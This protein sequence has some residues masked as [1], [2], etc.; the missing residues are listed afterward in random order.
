MTIITTYEHDARALHTARA[1][2]HMHAH[3]VTI[4]QHTHTRTHTHDTHTRTRTH[5]RAHT[6]THTCTPLRTAHTRCGVSGSIR[7]YTVQ[8]NHIHTYKHIHCNINVYVTYIRRPFARAC[9]CMHDN[10]TI[11]TLF[12]S[13]LQFSPSQHAYSKKH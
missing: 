13:S 6:H 7:Q 10:K 11:P 5:A 4:T 3:R 9:T 2:V 1:Y 8:R 12:S